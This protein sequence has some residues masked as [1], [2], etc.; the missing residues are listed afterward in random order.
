MKRAIGKHFHEAHC[1]R[2]RV[3]S[4]HSAQHIPTLL[5]A[6][7]CAGL[8]TMLRHV[9]CCWLKFENGQTFHA[10]L[11]M[12]H[13]VVVVWLGSCNNVASRHAH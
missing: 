6:T 7:C 8:A 5:G 1:L 9:G 4:Q 10:T 3:V 12:L 11:R 2:D 13:D